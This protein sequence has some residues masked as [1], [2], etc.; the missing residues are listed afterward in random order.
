MTN[1]SRAAQVIDN[2]LRVEMI[3]YKSE[4][5]LRMKLLAIEGDD[6]GGFLPAMLKSVKAECCQCGRIGM[7][8]HA[9][10]T[11]FFVQSIVIEAKRRLFCRT[12][13]TRKLIHFSVL[14]PVRL[15]RRTKRGTSAKRALSLVC[16]RRR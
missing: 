6:A 16:F 8:E 2:G 15:T 12:C 5:A 10:D 11:A 1:R 4:S 7:V 3:A 9:E 13:Q 14:Y